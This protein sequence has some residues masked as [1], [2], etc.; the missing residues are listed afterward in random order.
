[1]SDP[2]PAGIRQS[3]GLMV[4]YVYDEA[5]VVANHEAYVNEGRIAHS[6]E[7]AALAGTVAEKRRGAARRRRDPVSAAG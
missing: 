1:M 2:S 3:A 7:I 5:T 4:N 6:R